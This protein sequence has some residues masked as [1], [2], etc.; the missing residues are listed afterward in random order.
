LSYLTKKEVSKILILGL[1]ASGK[2]TIINTTTEGIIPKKDEEYLPTIDYVRKKVVIAGKELI[3]FDLGGQ[4]GFLDRFTTELSEF[5]FTGVKSLV[6]VVD[7]VD[8]KQ[9]SSAKYYLDIALQK[10]SEYSPDAVAYLFQHKTDLIPGKLREEVNK[11]ISDHLLV[12]APADLKYYET[13]V[14]DPSIFN[15]MGK[16][17]AG[18]SNVGESLRPLVETFIGH[19]E[20]EM[21]QVFT[22]EGVPLIHT[23]ETMKI[24][25]ISL[26]EVK[27][28]FNSVVQNLANSED[29]LSSSVLLESNNRIFIFKFTESG[30][31]LFLGFHKDHL[32]EKVEPI[33]SLFSKVSKFSLQL[34]NLRK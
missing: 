11:T 19:N 29:Q 32:Q 16:V 17:F 8:V 24:N 10:L 14:Y 26:P 6:F 34:E 21:A 5:I 20:V 23:E 13:S 25:Y 22:K 7:S 3:I 4:T 18:A 9:I 1:E 33:P 15:A 30:L 27:K 31:I 2:T 28:V 12:D